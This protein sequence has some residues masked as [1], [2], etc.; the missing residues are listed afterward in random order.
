MLV[1]YGDQGKTSATNALCGK[2]F[3]ETKSK[4]AGSPP[5]DKIQRGQA[6]AKPDVFGAPRREGWETVHPS[7][8]G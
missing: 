3:Q 1:K 6:I 4:T 2:K 7:L 8:R 5:L